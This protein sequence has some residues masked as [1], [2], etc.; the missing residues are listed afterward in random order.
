MNFIAFLWLLSSVTPH[1][2][3]IFAY[4][5]GL[6]LQQW[7]PHHEFVSLS[8]LLR[9]TSIVST[10]WLFQETE[11]S[12]W[13]FYDWLSPFPFWMIGILMIF[14]GLKINMTVYNKLGVNGVYYACEMIQECKYVQGY[15]FNIFDHPMYMGAIMILMGCILLIGIN[16][17]YHPRIN[18]WI[19][20]VWMMGLYLF[21]MYV[22][23]HRP[24]Q[25]M[26]TSLY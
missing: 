10:I 4:H 3:Y 1:I 20:L 18:V 5:Y 2:L 22:E 21:T 13:E 6:S 17:D 9:A 26:N 14:Y 19:P 8:V 16:E 11:F 25:K 23:S 7:I 15:P 12:T 24:I